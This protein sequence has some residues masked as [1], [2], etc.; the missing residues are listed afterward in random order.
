ML[1]PSLN[2]ILILP[3]VFVSVSTDTAAADGTNGQ[4]WAD[5]S[6][7]EQRLREEK[8]QCVAEANLSDEICRD[9]DDIEASECQENF[10][11]AIEACDVA[12]EAGLAPI[13]DDLASCLADAENPWDPQG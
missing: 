3:L 8:S 6:E 13:Q 4:C 9:I 2:L 7:A 11:F 1:K 5:Y 12:Y 10:E